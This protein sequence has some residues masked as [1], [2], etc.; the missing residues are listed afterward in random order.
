MPEAWP[1]RPVLSTVAYIQPTT[2]RPPRADEHYR[3]IPPSA[4]AN[5]I[6]HPAAWTILI[7]AAILVVWFTSRDDEPPRR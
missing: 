2:L 6:L 4:R 7:I 1:N 3:V 5:M